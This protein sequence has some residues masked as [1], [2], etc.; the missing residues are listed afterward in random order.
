MLC[1]SVA[2]QEVSREERSDGDEGSVGAVGVGDGA[3]VAGAGLYGAD[4][5]AAGAARRRVEQVPAAARG[6]GWRPEPGGP[7]AVCCRGAGKEHIVASHVEV[8]VLAGRLLARGWRD[9]RG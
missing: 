7:R 2:S 4:G 6:D 9:S 3:A 5:G 8:V 1:R